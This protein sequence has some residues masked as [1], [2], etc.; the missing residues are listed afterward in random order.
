MIQINMAEMLEGLCLFQYKAPRSSMIS[1]FH[2]LQPASAEMDAST[3]HMLSANCHLQAHPDMVSKQYRLRLAPLSKLV[4]ET[5]SVHTVCLRGV[6]IHKAY[7][8]GLT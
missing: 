5:L 3:F 4:G 6:R 2:R 1:Q 7:C 8:L